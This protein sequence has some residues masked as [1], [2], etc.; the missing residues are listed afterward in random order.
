MSFSRPRVSLLTLMF[1]MTIVALSF[2]LWQANRKYSSV[3]EPLRNEVHRLRNE[4]GQLQIDDPTKIHVRLSKVLL[5]RH[6]WEWRI[7]LP[8]NRSYLLYT[9][10]NAIPKEGFP[11]RKDWSG[12]AFKLAPGIEGM[13]FPT[14]EVISAPSGEF[15]LRVGSREDD[16]GRWFVHRQIF[17]VTPDGGRVRIGSERVRLLN[18]QTQ[19]YDPWPN[20]SGTGELFGRQRIHP[21]EKRLLLLQK[22]ALKQ[23]KT[24]L[25]PSE[26]FMVWIEPVP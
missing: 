14:G 10:T 19:G 24:I 25:T 16:Q 13:R 4:T 12:K 5:E 20:S 2:G 26:G 11:T 15:I 23:G 6:T 22:R 7:H 21:P 1:V 18:D 9:V 3:L 17:L 8:L